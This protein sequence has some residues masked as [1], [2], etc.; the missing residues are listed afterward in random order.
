MNFYTSYN[1]TEEGE[2]CDLCVF[3]SMEQLLIVSDKR[4]WRQC[5]GHCTS[6]KSLL[7]YFR[8]YILEQVAKGLMTQRPQQNSF[9]SKQNTV[10]SKFLSC[11]TFIIYRVLLQH[12][13]Q[14][15]KNSISHEQHVNSHRRHLR[16]H[17]HFVV[18][19]PK[20]D[21]DFAVLQTREHWVWQ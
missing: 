5:S 20:A 11:I 8:R 10:C 4:W 1:C 15:P 13:K 14:P 7:C 16:C 21:P 9:T 3:N 19:S 17:S 12:K 2:N 18:L 6:L